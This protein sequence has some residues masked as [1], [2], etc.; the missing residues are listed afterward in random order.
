M[1]GG[2][3]EVKRLVELAYAK[4]PEGYRSGWFWWPLAAHSK[5]A[6]LQRHLLAVVA[7]TVEVAVRAGTELQQIKHV[8]ERV[9]IP[10]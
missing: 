7:S 1:Q 6:D 5:N 10:V 3:L 8:G 9:R 2:A 4:L